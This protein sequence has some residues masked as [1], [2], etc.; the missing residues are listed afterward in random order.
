[1]SESPGKC[2]PIFELTEEERTAMIRGARR[3]KEQY[4]RIPFYADRA[5]RSG[6]EDAYWLKF[7]ASRIN[8]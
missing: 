2:M 7:F 5:R 1:M 4:S 3:L 8:S 6:D